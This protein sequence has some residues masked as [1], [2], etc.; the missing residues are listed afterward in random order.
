MNELREAAQET[1]ELAEQGGM[2]DQCFAE[3]SDG[4]Q[5]L[6][7]CT[8]GALKRALAAPRAPH[9]TLSE[10]LAELRKVIPREVVEQAVRD[11]YG[12]PRA[13]EGP[14]RLSPEGY[15]GTGAWF[16]ERDRLPANDDI[17]LIEVNSRAEAEAVRD[18][19]NR[20][21]G[22]VTCA[23]PEPTDSWGPG[24]YQ[25][26][27][28]EIRLLEERVREWRT[29]AEAQI[30]DGYDAKFWNESYRMVRDAVLE[31][32][33]RFVQEDD[34]AEEAI[35]VDAIERAGKHADDGESDGGYGRGE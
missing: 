17:C 10:T 23:L 20:V 3:V 6:A 26:A 21:A 8:I 5:H 33:K 18:A 19:L 7:D 28:R 32:L 35:I 29:L 11:T 25:S 34:V 12:A 13:L 1:V 27:L 2:C 15:Y 31:H 30:V 14:W 4:D 9:N 22:G 24:D 16:V